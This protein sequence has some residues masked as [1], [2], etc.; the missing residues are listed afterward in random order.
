MLRA[1]TPDDDRMSQGGKPILSSR[2]VAIPEPFHRVIPPGRVAFGAGRVETDST[3]RG[4]VS[5]RGLSRSHAH[6]SRTAKDPA[7]QSVPRY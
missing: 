4:S 1:L 2:G 7:G 6:Y 3:S 5:A